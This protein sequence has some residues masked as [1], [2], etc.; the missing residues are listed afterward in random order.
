MKFVSLLLLLISFSAFGQ[1]HHG[2]ENASNPEVFFDSYLAPISNPVLEPGQHAS[3]IIN[4][5]GLD[6]SYRLQLV[7]QINSKAAQ[8]FWY[9]LLINDQPV[10]ASEFHL[11][12]NFKNEAIYLDASRVTVENL[13]NTV[14]GKTAEQIRSEAKAEKILTEKNMWVQTHDGILEPA[15]VV[16]LAGPETLYRELIV[17]GTEVIQNTDLLKYSHQ[18]TQGPNDSLVEVMIFEP[19]PITSAMKNYGWPYLDSNDISYPLINAERKTKMIEFTYANNKFFPRNDYVKIID[20]SNPVTA[21]IASGNHQYFFNRD[22]FGFEDVNAL[23]HITNHGKHLTALGYP[24]L[25]G[26]QIE[27]DAHS[28]D[29]SDQSFFAASFTPPRLFFGEGGVDD[30]EDA[31]VIIHE[32]THAVIDQAAIGGSTAAERG[33]IEEA[34]GDYYAASYSKTINANNKDHVFSWDGHNEYWKG[35]MVISTAFYPDAQFVGGSIYQHTALFASALMEIY[36]MLGRTLSDELVTETL[37]NLRSTT[38]MPQ[39][40]RA[41]IKNDSLMYGGA[42][43]NVIFRAFENRLILGHISIQEINPTKHSFF[44]LKGSYEFSLG[45]S[46]QLYAYDHNLIEKIEIYDLTGLKLRDIK[47]GTQ[48]CSINSFGL[49]KGSYLLKVYGQNG[50]EQV[51]KLLKATR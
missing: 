9:Q 49:P 40:A 34:L 20:F 24:N 14:V 4:S 48:A 6:E 25:P 38:T 35:R 26:Y 29:N 8:H 41:M 2:H 36:D 21:S 22:H 50:T 39:F 5:I 47:V 30:A 45:G 7:H 23:Y 32:Y 46:A 27:V 44:E 51:F 37:F 1:K 17:V 3:F 13:K 31:D 18:H 42:N 15:L 43:K 16:T 10:Y 11:A 19:D 28:L 12:L 33:T